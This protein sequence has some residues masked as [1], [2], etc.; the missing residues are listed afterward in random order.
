MSFDI[1]D[2]KNIGGKRV[3]G[4]FPANL[5]VIRFNFTTNQWEFI[6]QGTSIDGANVGAGVG[7]IFRDKVGTILNFKTLINGVNMII[8]NQADD[9][10]LTTSAEINIAGNVGAGTG[11]I[12]RGKTGVQLDFKTLIAGAGI[13][14][15]NNANDIEIVSAAGLGDL[16]FLRDKELAGDLIISTGTTT[17]AAPITITSIIPA[18]GKTFF[19]A[20][21]AHV[22]ADNN[23]G[24]EVIESTLQN[25][26]VNKDIKTNTVGNTNQ[27]FLMGVVAGDS[28]VGDGAIVY[29][30]QKT[31][32]AIGTKISATITGWIQDT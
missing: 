11:L 17:A 10:I 5:D 30:I 9:I 1:N 8:T 13:T 3:Q 24:P 15:N 7:L 2:Q 28:L 27:L 18:V 20:S 6:A 26:G 16:E 31:V 19:I 23:V 22:H 4:G 12:F 32:G 29:R 14:I 25:N 21:S